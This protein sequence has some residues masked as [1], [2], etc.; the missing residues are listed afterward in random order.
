[1]VCEFKIDWGNEDVG[2][3]TMKQEL[4]ES[5]FVDVRFGWRV[6]DL[7]IAVGIIDDKMMSFVEKFEVL[8]ILKVLY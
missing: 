8:N 5:L 1:M 4:S 3:P 6:K 2:V 7:N